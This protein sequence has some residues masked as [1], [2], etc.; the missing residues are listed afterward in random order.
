M[1]LGNLAQFGMAVIVIREVDTRFL[2]LFVAEASGKL[3]SEI[4]A[5]P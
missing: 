4:I 2:D 5:T 3:P 1:S